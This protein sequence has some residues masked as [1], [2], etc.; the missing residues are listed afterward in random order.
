MYDARPKIV[1]YE[2]HQNWLQKFGNTKLGKRIKNK[3]S[4]HPGK[5]SAS[6]KFKDKLIFEC[7]FAV[8]RLCTIC[9]A[10]QFGMT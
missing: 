3:K 2:T 9:N 4:S 10:A 5:L 6:D 8:L 1:A 7:D